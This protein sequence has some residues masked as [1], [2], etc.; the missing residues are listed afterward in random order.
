M[1]YYHH[2]FHL[3]LTLPRFY[4]L[5]IYH[6]LH[7]KGQAVIVTHLQSHNSGVRGARSGIKIQPHLHPKFEASLGY[8][9]LV[10]INLYTLFLNTQ[11][12]A[13]TT[14]LFSSTIGWN[15]SLQNF[16]QQ[17]NTGDNEGSSQVF[18]IILVDFISRL[19]KLV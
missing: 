14:K 5:E 12:T 13:D 1:G 17:T 18:W 7:P 19:N 10:S 6:T 2:V 8:R 4:R 16:S 15:L 11:N 3:N 9:G